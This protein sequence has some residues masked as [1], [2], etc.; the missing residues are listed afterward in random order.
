MDTH[1]LFPMKN[2]ELCGPFGATKRISHWRLKI[3]G[4]CIGKLNP[5]MAELLR[6]VSYNLP[7]L[8]GKMMTNCQVW[9]FRCLDIAIHCRMR[10]EQAYQAW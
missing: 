5:F 4:F 3:D 7:R 2:G 9:G 6:L 1:I 8:I 10:L